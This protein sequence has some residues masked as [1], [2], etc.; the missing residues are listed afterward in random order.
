VPTDE[1]VFRRITVEPEP[2]HDFPM[3]D[4]KEVLN[5]DF[6]DISGHR[7]LLP[8]NSD[9]TMRTGRI[10]SRNEI[11]FRKYQ[12]YSADTSITFGDDAVDDAAPDKAPPADKNPP[13]TQP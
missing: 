9:V 11:E 10:G 3:Q 5:Y 7:F 4:V 6:V 8:V 12:K 2:P 13:K 1:S